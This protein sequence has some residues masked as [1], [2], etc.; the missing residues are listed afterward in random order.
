MRFPLMI[1]IPLCLSACGQTD[2][3]SR[4][5]EPFGAIGENETITAVGTEPFWSI[6]ITR[7]QAFFSSPEQMDGIAFE[8]S[9]FAGNNGLGF[10]GEMQGEKLNLT[11]TPGQCSDGMSDRTFPYTATLLLGDDTLEGCAHTDIQAFEE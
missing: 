8:V 10:S 5:T 9:R 4:D 2:G 11:I 1:A 3:I 6:E 7:D